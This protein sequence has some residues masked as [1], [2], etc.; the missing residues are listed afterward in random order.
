MAPP[1]VTDLIS[2]YRTTLRPTKILLPSAVEPTPSPPDIQLLAVTFSLEEV[3]SRQ[4]T[5]KCFTKE[6]IKSC[7]FVRFM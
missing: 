2:T 7:F 3:I 5:L 1:L 4:L 6:V